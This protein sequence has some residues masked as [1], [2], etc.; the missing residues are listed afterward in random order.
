MSRT[1]LGLNL[2]MCLRWGLR[3]LLYE[4]NILH[5]IFCQYAIQIFG[6]HNMAF[7]NVYSGRIMLLNYQL[8]HI[9]NRNVNFD[10][11][12]TYQ[13]VS[14]QF[15]STLCLMLPEELSWKSHVFQAFICHICSSSKSS[16]FLIAFLIW[17]LCLDDLQR[18][19]CPVLCICCGAKPRPWKWMWRALS[20]LA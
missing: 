12:F 3:Y 15:H 13:G 6:Y 7:H 17:L 16:A 4:D 9:S 20:L 19:K 2:E 18:S 5:L 8:V 11:L 10:R 14:R 1:V